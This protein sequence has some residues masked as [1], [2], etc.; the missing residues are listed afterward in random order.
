M[1]IETKYKNN[2]KKAKAM[3][4]ASDLEPSPFDT[5]DEVA[6]KFASGMISR[7]DYYIKLN[8]IDLI[9]RF[10]NENGS[11]AT[12]GMELRYDVKIKRIKD[13]LINYANQTLES[14]ESTDDNSEQIEPGGTGTS[15][16]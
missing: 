5:R 10:E 12:F 13:T 14:N 8:F 4:I 16:I 1:L 6:A 9:T 15:D 7:E 3:K 11:L 2:P